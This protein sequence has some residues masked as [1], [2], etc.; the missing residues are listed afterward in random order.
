MTARVRLALIAALSLVL[1]VVPACTRAYRLTV[2]PTG[3]AVTSQQAEALAGSI[4][5]STLASVSTTEAPSM[6]ATVLEQLRT[7]GSFGL[8]AAELLTL[9]FPAR[10]ASVPVLVRGCRVDGVD[11]VL[12]VE[13]WGSTGG[14]LTHRRLWVF[15][16]VKGT[17]LRAASFR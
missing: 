10:T 12:V 16:R 3:A 1:L 15:D 4:D 14:M 13:A 11:A 2:E 7:Q 9:G 17:V 8:R 5:I 6:R